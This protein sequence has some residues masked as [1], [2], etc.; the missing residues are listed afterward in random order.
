MAMVIFI[1]WDPFSVKNH[2]KFNTS[3]KWFSLEFFQQSPKLPAPTCKGAAESH[4]P[5]SC[6][7]LEVEGTQD[8]K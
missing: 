7:L 4:A 3:K 2:L 6:S 1:P 5:K 8:C